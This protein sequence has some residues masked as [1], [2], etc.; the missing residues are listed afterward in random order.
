MFD[1]GDPAGGAGALSRTPPEQASMC[2]CVISYLLMT[3]LC[4]TGVGGRSTLVGAPISCVYV[5][6]LGDVS[7]LWSCRL[8]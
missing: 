7:L 3:Y 1:E 8:W 5:C 2:V 4:H 6:V